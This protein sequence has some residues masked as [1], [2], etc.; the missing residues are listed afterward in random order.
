MC[1]VV[2]QRFIKFW[3][4]AEAVYKWTSL[5]RF[6]KKHE[7]VLDVLTSRVIFDFKHFNFLKKK[8]MSK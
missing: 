2:G 8:K 1:E 5:Y 4:H 3:A 7:Q 6:Q